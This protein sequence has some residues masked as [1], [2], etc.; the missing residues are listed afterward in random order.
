MFF[1]KFLVILAVF[2][3]GLFV[4]I[5]VHTIKRRKMAD[6]QLTLK[7][8]ACSDN[9]KSISVSNKNDGEAGTE[10]NHEDINSYDGFKSFAGEKAGSM[11]IEQ[12]LEDADRIRISNPEDFENSCF[13]AVNDYDGGETLLLCEVSE[14]VF[15]EIEIT[16]EQMKETEDSINKNEVDKERRDAMIDEILSSTESAVFKLSNI[17]K[18][19]D[20]YYQRHFLELVNGCRI[21]NKLDKL[22]LSLNLCRIAQQRSVSLQENGIEDEDASVNEDLTSVFQKFGYECGMQCENL[23]FSSESLFTAKQVYDYWR[24][25]EQFNRNIL[26]PKIKRIGL[27]YNNVFKNMKNYNYWVAD[28]TD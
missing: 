13:D 6:Y 11:T 17:D 7:N 1:K 3:S 24:D 10:K 4:A 2:F 12:I 15:A 16:P 20:K 21:E 9:K 8:N 28:F 14:P 5:V 19:Q 27:S 18:Q 22:K 23:A 25:N 26:D